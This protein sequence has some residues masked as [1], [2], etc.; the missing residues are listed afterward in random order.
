MFSS[1]ELI[2]ALRRRMRRSLRPLP[3][4]GEFP[5]GWREWFAAMAARPGQVSGASA[6]DVIAVA[7][8]RVPAPPPLSLEEPGRWRAF[9]Q[10][11]RQQWQP[12]SSDERWARV[13]SMSGSLL[14]H[15][16]FALAIVWL[17]LVRFHFP[18]P[19]A[20]AR[21]GEEHVLQV[22]YIGEGTPAEAGGGATESP[23]ELPEAAEPAPA[24]AAAAAAPPVPRQQ[25]QP[26]PEPEPLP[27]QPAPEALAELPPPLP[28]REIVFEVPPLSTPEV[29]VATQALQVTE[30]DVADRRFEVPPPREQVI[31]APD[32]REPV[33]VAVRRRE[34]A[35]E[36]PVAVQAPAVPA[37]RETVLAVPEVAPQGVAVAERRIE[38]A[39]VREVT[40]AS[41]QALAE[42]RI[43]E[44]TASA[45]AVRERA[46]PMPAARPAADAS[47]DAGTAATGSGQAPAPVTS[48][49][50]GEGRSAAPVAGPPGGRP[51]AGSGARTTGTPPGAGAD[52]TQPPGALPSTLASDDWGDSVRSAPGR[53][54]GTPGASG[55]FNA[56][57]SPRLAGDGRVGGGLPPGTITEDFE[58]IDR[59]GT[60]L[61]RPPYD[62]EP[63]SFDR[64]WM[65]TETLLEEWVRKSVTEVRIPIPGTTKTIRCV[66]VML[67]L[68]GACD[69]VD[70]NLQEQ[71]AQARKPPDVPF[72]RE[73]Q[74]DQGSL[75]PRS[76][77]EP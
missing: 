73:L 77:P 53:Q 34:I 3:P 31:E 30:V 9:S 74:E 67:A 44:S 10:L 42:I 18:A 41:G 71:P 60:W 16:L 64:F 7:A 39:E 8:L 15:L 52:P 50:A 45:P 72:K 46:V 49:E 76:P 25:P 19:A 13:A 40:V 69:I 65:P 27:P 47:T 22:E 54:A 4:P 14:L 57:G 68:G 51:E 70:P 24:A 43:R 62:Y 61:K 37:A 33:E 55:L 63:T 75:G 48:P 58:N 17:M 20:D 12:E 56:D 26:L 59:H 36:T 21:D 2:E 28:E 11:W 1:A 5:P 29:A 6:E 32:T 23:L 35:L 66:T 38:L